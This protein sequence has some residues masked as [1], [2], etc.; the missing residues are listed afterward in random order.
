MKNVILRPTLPDPAAEPTVSVERA[1]LLLGI[2]RGSAYAAARSGDLPTVRV[3]RRLLVPSA[4][5]RKMLALDD[6]PT[7]W[8]A[9]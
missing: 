5:L 8:G 1:G 2:S 4:A 9:A 6:Q 7:D 3:G